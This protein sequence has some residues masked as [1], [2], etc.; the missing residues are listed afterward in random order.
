LLNDIKKEQEFVPDFMYIQSLE[1][2]CEKLEKFV[3]VYYNCFLD[4]R[5]KNGVY[6]P[7]S[8][9]DQFFI[10]ARANELLGEPNGKRLGD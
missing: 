3:K 1:D 10:Y 9:N 7:I 6:S 8:N 2:Y 4:S 5:A